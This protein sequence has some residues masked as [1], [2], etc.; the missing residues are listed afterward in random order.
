MHNWQDFVQDYSVREPGRGTASVNLAEAVHGFFAN[1]GRSCLV[2][3]TDGASPA[4]YTAALA[5]LEGPD[6]VNIVVVPDLWQIEDD[7]PAIAKAVAGHCVRMGNRMAV[8]HPKQAA[9]PAEAEK[10]PALF[11]LDDTESQFT[12]LYYPWVNVPGVGGSARVVPPSGHVAGIWARTDA[13][14]GVHR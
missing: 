3:G 11:A 12:T 13:D 7:A 8:L 2:V 10:A 1:G 9:T 14:R 4:A 5:A 6:E